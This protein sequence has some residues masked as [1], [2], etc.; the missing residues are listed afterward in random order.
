MRILEVPGAR[1][2]YA[3]HGS[4]P[5][6]LMV[7]GATGEADSFKMVTEHLAAHCTVVIYDQRGFSRS[8]LEGPQDYDQRLAT[9][10]DDVRRLIEHVSD[11]PAILFGASSGG[12]VVLAVLAHHPSVVRTLV[13]F[14]PAAVRQLPDGQR[15]VDFFFEIY[16]LYREAGMPSALEKFREQAF[17]ESDRQVMAGARDSKNSEY[18]LANAT[19][20]F[21]HELR[22]YPAVDLDLDALKAHADRIVPVAGRESRGHPCYEVNVELGK[23]LGRD[24]IELPGGHVGYVAQPAEFAHELVQ[25]LARTGHG[26]QA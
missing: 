9:D 16:D 5:L 25:A 1:L 21:E 12:V 13:P 17:A 4:G 24:V 18:V 10:A 7:P 11:E 15:W 20:W 3:T 8:R 6:M 14:E 2:S 26:S 23:K 22:Q 19:Y